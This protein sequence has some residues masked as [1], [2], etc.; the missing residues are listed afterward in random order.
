[1]K[2]PELGS[3][4]D[5]LIFFGVLDRSSLGLVCVLW[6][7]AFFQENADDLRLFT[8]LC[9]QDQSSFPSFCHEI[10]FRTFLDEFFNHG[11]RMPRFKGKLQWS[12]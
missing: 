12:L 7:H 2:Q 3:A 11:R 8:V 10:R 1:M 5:L 6:V 9:S 4:I